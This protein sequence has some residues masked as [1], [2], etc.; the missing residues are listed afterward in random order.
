M[1]KWAP[2]NKWWAAT[3]TTAGTVALMFWTAGG[4][5]TDDKKVV[6]V[7]LIVQRIVAYVARNEPDAVREARRVAREAR[8]KS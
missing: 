6:L 1:S 2:T 3:A 4:V 5:D 8:A 7:G